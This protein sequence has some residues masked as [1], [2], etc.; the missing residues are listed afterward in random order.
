MPVKDCLLGSELKVGGLKTQEEGVMEKN[1]PMN[2]QQCCK[3]NCAWF[4]SKTETD[5]GQKEIDCC[6]IRLIALAM[7][8]FISK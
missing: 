1:C 8:K 5:A 7:S 4:I 6:A 3:T 2:N